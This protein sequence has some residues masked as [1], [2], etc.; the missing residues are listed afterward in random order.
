V[1]DPIKMICRGNEL[2]STI[3]DIA[4]VICLLSSTSKTCMSFDHFFS[5]VLS[6]LVG[7]R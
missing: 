3:E 5:H 4:I 1:V 2:P 6:P 7:I